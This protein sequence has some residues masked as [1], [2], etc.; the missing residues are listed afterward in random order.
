MRANRVRRAGNA[1]AMAITLFK[2]SCQSPETP[3]KPMTEGRYQAKS[4][5]N[6]AKRTTKIAVSG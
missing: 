3:A 1:H 5:L 2:Q 4:L 6:S